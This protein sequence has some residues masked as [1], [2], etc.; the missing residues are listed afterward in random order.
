MDVY[1]RLTETAKEALA[2]T[3]VAV[4]ALFD[5]DRRALVHWRSGR[6]YL[7][8]AC[9][10]HEQLA[11]SYLETVL[12]GVPAQRARYSQSLDANRRVHYPGLPSW[13]HAVRIR[14]TGGATFDAVL[15]Q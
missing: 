12:V 4:A 3:V 5:V 7:Q 2:K 9:A 15:D 13:N 6:P 11:S 8:V 1:L 10:F 14:S